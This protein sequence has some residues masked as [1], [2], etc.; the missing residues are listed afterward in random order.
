MILHQDQALA[1]RFKVSQEVIEISLKIEVMSH[2]LF[3]PALAICDI[4]LFPEVKNEL[5]VQPFFGRVLK[6][7]MK[8]DRHGFSRKR[9]SSSNMPKYFLFDENFTIALAI[10]MINNFKLHMNSRSSIN[11]NA[12]AS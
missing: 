11:T 6:I 5:H 10:G 3:S 9:T 4:F 2:P 12:S 8:N 7:I 1:L